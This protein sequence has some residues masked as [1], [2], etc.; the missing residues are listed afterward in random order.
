MSA[1]TAVLYVSVVLPDR[2]TVLLLGNEKDGWQLPTAVVQSGESVQQAA[3]RAVREATGVAVALTN[4]V[5]M[6]TSPAPSMHIV[7][8]AYTTPDRVQPPLGSLARW[9]T[10]DEALALIGGEQGPEALLPRI[11]DDVQRGIRFPLSVLV[12]QR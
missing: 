1:T 2:G 5:G 6:Y 3:Q 7:F 10:P 11:L 4:L 12:E 8:T 9:T